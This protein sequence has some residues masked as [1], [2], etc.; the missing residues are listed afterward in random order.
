MPYVFHKKVNGVSK[1]W[2]APFHTESGNEEWIDDPMEAT[3]FTDELI[4][5][6]DRSNPQHFPPTAENIKV[7]LSED[8]P[9][10][11]FWTIHRDAEGRIISLGG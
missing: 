7:I 5:R 4:M 1:Y 3:N 11:D 10:Q 2:L 9:V 6:G 8:L